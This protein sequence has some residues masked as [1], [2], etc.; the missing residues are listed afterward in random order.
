MTF[1]T[2]IIIDSSYSR[3]RIVNRLTNRNFQKSRNLKTA[4]RVL[5]LFKALF[6]HF[7]RLPINAPIYKVIDRSYSRPR[8]VNRLTNR[9]FQ[10]SRNPETAS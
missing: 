3:P 2:P 8:I 5:I 7:S 9:N 10:K 6:Y 4:F 1:N